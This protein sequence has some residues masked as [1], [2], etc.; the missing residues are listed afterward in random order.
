MSTPDCKCDSS[1]NS[2]KREHKFPLSFIESAVFHSADETPIAFELDVDIL[3][4][5]KHST[6][7]SLNNHGN[8]KDTLVIT[9]DV[10]SGEFHLITA[11]HGGTFHGELLDRMIE[12]LQL[13]RDHIGVI[14]EGSGE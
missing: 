1:K 5:L 13:A 2:S 14:E 7:R 4:A 3:H 12:I 9:T 8:G 11:D 6:S 10:D